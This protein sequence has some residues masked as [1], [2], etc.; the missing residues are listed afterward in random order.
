MESYHVLIVDDQKDIRRVLAGGLQ[1]LGHS[2]KVTEV[3]SAEEA[4]LM[5]PRQQFDLIVT[6]VRLPGISGLDMVKRLR[7]FNPNIKIILLTGASD[8][9]TSKQVE[10]A[11]NI[12]YFYK[13]IEMSDFLDAV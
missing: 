5:A 12:A 2:L 6:D 11:G 10:E 7:K 1:T 13:P 9:Q 3:P 4:I 8:F